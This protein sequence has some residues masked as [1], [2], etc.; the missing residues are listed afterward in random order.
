MSKFKIYISGLK[1]VFKF[2]YLLLAAVI[3]TTI[4]TVLN[5]YTPTITAQILDAIT[6]EILSITMKEVTVLLVLFLVLTIV[7]FILRYIMNV[8]FNLIGLKV[9]RK[10]REDAIAKLNDL[11]IDYFSLEPDGKIVAKITSDSNGVRMLFNVTFNIVQAAINIII[12]YTALI[13]I[14]P[15]L[16][17]Y[18]LIVI[19]ILL[20]WITVY[21]KKIHDAT[22]KLRELSSRITGKLAELISGT[23][24]IQAYNQ[25]ENMMNEYKDLVYSHN[26]NDAKVNTVS[27][28]FG[29]ELIHLIK[30]FIE[31]G[32][33]AY[34]GFLFIKDPTVAITAS[35][36]YLYITY[37]DRMV[38]PINTIFDNLNAFEDSVV[39]TQR[40]IAFIEED[41]DE[42]EIKQDFP[43]I[44][45]ADVIFKDVEFSYIKGTKILKKLNLNIKDGE[46]IGIV[47]HTG[48]GKSTLMN[49]LLRFN[50]Y[51]SGSILVDGKEIN[52][53]NK[54]T[55]RNNLGI[56][57]QTPSIFKGTLKS[58]V[59]LERDYYTD[60][61]V[62]NVL[63]LVGAEFLIDKFSKGINQEIAFKGENLSL[64]E[65]QLIAFSRILL[66]NPKILVLDEATANIDTETEVKIKN[67]MNVITK[68]RTTFI[69]AHRLSTIKD[70]DKIVVI[71][72]GIVNGVGTHSELLE[73]CEKYQDMYN[74]Q[75]S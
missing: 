51:Q 9:E 16:A 69:I 7:T 25:E 23:S 58:N 27:I 48:S 15:K 60:E 63:K 45:K 31:A 26:D 11:P 65:K 66:R 30:R 71:D 57:L 42:L 72:N 5:T 24:I 70:A 4:I 59:T 62:I 50:D 61:E 28:F 52:E 64:G 1:Y 22:Q 49:L 40:V 47:G 34:F 68:G 32:M 67:A 36:I 54:R 55:Y 73:T 17:L 20:V 75:F 21:R 33:I 12:V 13:I 6:E 3:L 39:G 53:Y 8:L 19:P 44:N 2:W 46:T 29:W 56:V 18:M 37:V 41:N 43:E 74:S 14:E 35:T 38:Q 10:V